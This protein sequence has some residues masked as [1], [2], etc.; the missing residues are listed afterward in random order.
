MQFLNLIT[1][2][3]DHAKVLLRIEGITN[4]M[5][6]NNNM[7]QGRTGQSRWHIWHENLDTLDP[8]CGYISMQH[9]RRITKDGIHIR[10]SMRCNNITCK[11]KSNNNRK[12]KCW[13][14]IVDKYMKGSLYFFL[15]N[16]YWMN[17][18]YSWNGVATR[19]ALQ[20]QGR[21]LQIHSKGTMLQ[22]QKEMGYIDNQQKSTLNRAIYAMSGNM[23][24][25]QWK[26]TI[27]VRS[28]LIKAV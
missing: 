18:M 11:K 1:H 10:N 2:K 22:L 13:T 16:Y 3:I 23:L 19:R 26:W 27:C 21:I 7:Q 8:I 25:L 14:V 17:I 5:S 15:Y 9:S 28:R 12:T 24:E 4:E 20:D 6:L